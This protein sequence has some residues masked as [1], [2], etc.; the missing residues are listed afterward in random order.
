[1]GYALHIVTPLEKPFLIVH[2][3]TVIVPPHG[4]HLRRNRD[5]K[6]LFVLSG[7]ARHE[8]LHK[9]GRG[10]NVILRPGDI[11][12]LPHYCEQRYSAPDGLSGA[13]V[14]VVRLA[15]DTAFLP[16]LPL[17]HKPSHEIG[18]EQER[19]LMTLADL[20]LQEIHYLPQGQSAA[21]Q[22][23]LAQ[24]RDECQFLRPDYRIRVHALCTSL[25][26]LF[27]RSIR[28][29]HSA[30]RSPLAVLP[31]GDYH[32]TQIKDYLRENMHRPLRL[33]EIARHIQLTEEHA[34]R[35]FRRA[36][37]LTIQEYA[38]RMRMEQAK[39]YL[40]TTEKNLSE[41]AQLAGFASLTVFS[42]NFKRE[43]GITPSEYRRRIAGL[44]G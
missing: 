22:E 18:N 15:F 42:R 6:I 37:G 43:V 31:A 34:A 40:A 7:E 29:N 14:H 10:A 28:E 27:A 4:V 16:L 33:A 12:A 11:L 8:V 20:C 17:H 23:T 41:I 5:R 35:L 25:T 30:A 1:M 44:V 21:I 13:R 36:T 9:S 19:D 3:Q 2:E 32:S 24:L 26:V 38:R 39:H